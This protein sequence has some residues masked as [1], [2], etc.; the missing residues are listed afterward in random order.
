MEILPGAHSNV[1]IYLVEFL[2][3]VFSWPIFLQNP[4]NKRRIGMATSMT[5]P[6]ILFSVRAFS[7]VLARSPNNSVS[8]GDLRKKETLIAWLLDV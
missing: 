4:E 3:Q 6:L 5:Y 1:L 7:K 8:G 2:R